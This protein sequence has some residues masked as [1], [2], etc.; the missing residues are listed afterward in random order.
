MPTRMKDQLVQRAREQTREQIEKRSKSASQ[1][2]AAKWK[3][4]AKPAVA[5]MAE[6]IPKEISRPEP[7][8][9]ELENK[10]PESIDPTGFWRF[11]FW[12]AFVLGNLALAFSLLLAQVPR[13]LH[14]MDFLL[15]YA[16]RSSAAGI[17]LISI[18][19]ARWLWGIK[20]PI[21]DKGSATAIRFVLCTVWV[22]GA[23]AVIGIIGIAIFQLSH[24][25]RTEIEIDLQNH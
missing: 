14:D 18:L 2:I 8:V 24:H 20:N 17:M 1:K 11:L 25:W 3:S 10:A 4:G 15:D 19:M 5:S 22:E 13:G 6:L 9:G 21:T 7:V 23:I 12:L 16:F